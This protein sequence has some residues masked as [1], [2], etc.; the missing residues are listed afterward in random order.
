MSETQ[1]LVTKLVR[2]N[3][4]LRARNVKLERELERLSSG[5]EQIMQ[6][7]RSAPRKVRGKG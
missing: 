3:R 7:A 5:W 4:T 6:L 1:D 2:E